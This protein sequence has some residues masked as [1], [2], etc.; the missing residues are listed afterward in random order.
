METRPMKAMVLI[1]D[2]YENT[3][4]VAVMARERCRSTERL[5]DAEVEKVR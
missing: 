4:H 3:I 1:H 2:E 5:L